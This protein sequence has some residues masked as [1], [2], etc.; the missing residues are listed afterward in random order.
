MAFRPARPL[1][2]RR[3][4]AVVVGALAFALVLAGCGGSDG[5]DGSS[6]SDIVLDSSSTVATTAVPVTPGTSDEYADALVGSLRADEAEVPLMDD[7]QAACVGPAWVDAVTPD[8]FGASGL[9][10]SDVAGAAWA[11][12]VKQLTLT[13]EEAG[14]LVDALDTCGVDVRRTLIDSA[15]TMDGSPL[16]AEATACLERDLTEDLV[17]RYAAVGLS[18]AIADPLA[19]EVSGQYLAVLQAC[20]LYSTG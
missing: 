5:D 7:E 16:E 10:P 14:A 8:R 6:D 11:E 19:A 15:R 2:R 18:G 4:P 3:T 17:D 1:R 12:T 13:V 9:R 20:G